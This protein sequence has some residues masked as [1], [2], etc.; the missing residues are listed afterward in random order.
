[1]FN[2]SYNGKGGKAFSIC[3]FICNLN[4]GIQLMQLFIILTIT[5]KG[6]YQIIWDFD[7]MDS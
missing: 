5:A 7:S 4:I 6:N 2:G 1:M 3:S